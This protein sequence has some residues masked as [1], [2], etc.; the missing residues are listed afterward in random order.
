[1]I[2]EVKVSGDLELLS[3][4]ANGLPV[5]EEIDMASVAASEG[6]TSAKEANFSTGWC[7]LYWK[8]LQA[9]DGSEANMDAI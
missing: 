8:Q 2:V 9:A 6:P 3:L 1:M 7:F 4:L 5:S